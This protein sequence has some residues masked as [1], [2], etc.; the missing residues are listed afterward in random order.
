MNNI[1]FWDAV[2]YVPKYHLFYGDQQYRERFFA[3]LR[4]LREEGELQYPNAHMSMPQPVHM[5]SWIDRFEYICEQAL[6]TYPQI[7]IYLQAQLKDGV[8]DFK[9]TWQKI[10]GMYGIGGFTAYEVCLDLM[11]V[12]M[13]PYD[14][15]TWA[16]IGP[17]ARLGLQYLFETRRIKQQLAYAQALR[18]VQPYCME[19][20]GLDMHW[21]KGETLSLGNI[22]HSVCEFGK[23]VSHQHSKG[24]PRM[25]FDAEEA[26]EVP[27]FKVVAP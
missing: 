3:E 21:W 10:Q 9:D 2:G 1:D 20:L 26:Y 8:G 27:L 19:A 23:Y 17:G 24:R 4:R 5:A 13:L 11:M 12:D 6:F 15:D 7:V 16:H 22:I 18:D 14:P 25:N